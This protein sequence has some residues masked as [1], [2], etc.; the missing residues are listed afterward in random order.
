MRVLV[1]GASGFVGAAL[2]RELL[3]R[4][5]FV[6]AA[7]RRSGPPPQTPGAAQEVLVQDFAGDFDRRALLAGLDVVVHLAAI[8]HREAPEAEIRRVNVEAT[9]KLAEAAAGEVRRFVFMSSAKVHG[10]DSGE[11]SFVETSPQ[12]PEDAYGRAKLEAERLLDDLAARRGMEL[13]LI[14]PPLVYGPGVK[15]NFLRLLR[16]LDSGLPLPLASV[17]NRRRLLYVGNLT[18]AI[19][20][21]VEHPGASGAFLLGDDEIVSTPEL[22]SRAARPLNRAAR[23]FPLPR[24]AL[25]LAGVIAGQGGE[26]RRLTGNLVVDASRARDV[27]GWR[28]RHTLDAGLEA[29][30]LWFS[31]ERG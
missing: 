26:I 4:G 23:L 2:C 27:L 14:R 20:R 15:A 1:T 24:G 11:G 16:W 13:S 22:L 18:D 21:C 8:A 6:R 28:P 10:E 25:R 12:R 29:T 7:V 19:A 3:A 9:V 17:R 30:A 31:S 5:H